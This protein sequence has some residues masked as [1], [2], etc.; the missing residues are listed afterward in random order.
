MQESNVHS[1]AL[2]LP[3]PPHPFIEFLIDLLL[4][5]RAIISAYLIPPFPI[6]WTSRLTSIDPV[7]NPDSAC[8]FKMYTPTRPLD[9]GNTTY[10]DKVGYTVETMGPVSVR[11]GLLVEKA[12]YAKEE[13]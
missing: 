5:S 2:G 7:T 13:N 3:S 12:F 4:S 6:S 1:L 10:T 8:P 11:K 9:F